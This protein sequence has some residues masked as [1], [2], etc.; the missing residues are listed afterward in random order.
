MSTCTDTVLLDAYLDGAMAPAEAEAYERHV[1]GCATCSEE[2]AL[3]RAV[4]SELRSAA[5][6]CPPEVF[7]A[8]V[9]RIAGDRPALRAA[10]RPARARIT[11]LRLGILALAASALIAALSVAPRLRPVPAVAETREPTPAEVARARADVERALG[12]IGTAT[13]DAGLFLRDDVLAPHV[14]EPAA[15]SVLDALG[16]N[17]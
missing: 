3:A 2:L 16:L 1:A 17:D 13:R 12:L 6:A 9:A 7:E 15:E 10:D 5:E 4:T 8:A 11:P 14:A